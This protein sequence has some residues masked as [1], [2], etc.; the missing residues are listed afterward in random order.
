MIFYV[1]ILDKCM[2]DVHCP[3][4][5]VMLCKPTVSIKNDNCMHTDRNML[6]INV[7][8]VNGNQN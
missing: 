8:H 1:Y 7:L 3:I 4:C 6:W 5:V 2:S